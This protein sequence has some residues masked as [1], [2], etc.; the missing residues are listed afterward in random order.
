MIGYATADSR[1]A[2]HGPFPQLRPFGQQRHHAG[3]SASIW[4]RAESATPAQAAQ[5][6]GL[7]GQRGPRRHAQHDSRWSPRLNCL[8]HGDPPGRRGDPASGLLEEY[9]TS[10]GVVAS[11]TAPAAAMPRTGRGWETC[12]RVLW[13]HAHPPQCGLGAVRSALGLA[14][15]MQIARVKGELFRRRRAGAVSRPE[16]KDQRR[17][18]GDRG[19]G[20]WRG[21]ARD[22]AR[23]VNSAPPPAPAPLSAL[24]GG[25]CNSVASGRDVGHHGEPGA[26]RGEADMIVAAVAR[27]GDLVGNSRDLRG[28]EDL[29]LR[30]GARTGRLPTGYRPRCVVGKLHR[31]ERA[32][33]WDNHPLARQQAGGTHHDPSRSRGRGGR[34]GHPA[35]GRLSP[36]RNGAHPASVF[37]ARRATTRSLGIRRIG[38]RGADRR[39]HL[40]R[41]SAFGSK[42]RADDQAGNQRPLVSQRCPDDMGLKTAATSPE[43]ACPAPSTRAARSS[44]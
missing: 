22:A 35:G 9:R 2:P 14:R 37:M 38:G 30:D 3:R 26:G 6:R 15:L 19:A 4:P 23:F 12:R 36:W 29:L 17:H 27:D 31:D 42:A 25:R 11:R 33:R 16:V 40:R 1:R 39:L 28:A 10:T 44:R 13:G 21:V 18:K 5:L 7:P 20:S 41:G 24:T 8:R 43:P 32:A 34:R